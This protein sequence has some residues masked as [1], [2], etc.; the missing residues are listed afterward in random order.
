MQFFHV[1]PAVFFQVLL[2]RFGQLLVTQQAQVGWYS[3]YYYRRLGC[4]TWREQSPLSLV[5][6]YGILQASDCAAHVG[7]EQTNPLVLY[8]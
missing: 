3:T 6:L 4:A 1:N 7:A 2:D 8:S 5:Q